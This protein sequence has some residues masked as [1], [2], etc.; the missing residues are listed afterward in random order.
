M[1]IAS[2]ISLAGSATASVVNE[3]ANI[4]TFALVV[5]H[6]VHQISGIMVSVI[7]VVAA[8][9][10]RRRRLLAATVDV[11]FKVGAWRWWMRACVGGIAEAAD[12]VQDYELIAQALKEKTDKRVIAMVHIKSFNSQCV[13]F[14]CFVFGA[15]AHVPKPSLCPARRVETSIFI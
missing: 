9:V 7:D 12:P 8:D 6:G 2:S 11:S 13:L 14:P 3:P 4:A 10:S 15:F 1:H 5:E